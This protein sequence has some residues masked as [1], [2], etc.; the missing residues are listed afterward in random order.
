M[1]F[2][3]A[4][5]KPLAKSVPAKTSVHDDNETS[6]IHVTV[7]TLNLVFPQHATARDCAHIAAK[8]IADHLNK[9]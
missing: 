4:P 2:K 1:D 7:G 3:P 9:S 5:I 6:T 8:A